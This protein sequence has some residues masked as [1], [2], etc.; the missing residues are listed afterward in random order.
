MMQQFKNRFI[1]RMID[2]IGVEKR[3]APVQKRGDSKN[4]EWLVPRP[5]WRRLECQSNVTEQ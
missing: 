5:K 4:E 2:Q 1:E 3:K